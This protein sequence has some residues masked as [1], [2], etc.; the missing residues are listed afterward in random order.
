MLQFMSKQAKV[1]VGTEAAYGVAM[2]IYGFVLNLFFLSL[3]LN[4]TQIGAITS[5]G[6]VVMGA[7][8][9]PLGFLARKTG[10][11]NMYAGGVLLIGANLV[12]YVFCPVRLLLF[13]V[14]FVAVGMTMVEV[15]EVQVMYQ[16]CES[17]RERVTVFSVSFATFSLCSALG[18][19]VAGRLPQFIGYRG[20]L[21]A[22]GILTVIVG[23]LRWK[24]LADD[25]VADAET[26]RPH[27]E[28][29]ALKQVLDRKFFS[30]LAVIAFHGALTNTIGP[31]STLILKYRCDWP[32]SSISTVLT[33]ASVCSFM[34]AL[35]TP[36]LQRKLYNTR[37]YVGVYGALI[38][39]LAT[40][41]VIGNVYLFAVL[42]VVRSGLEIM[43][44]NMI[45]SVTYLTLEESQKDIY[46]GARSLTKGAVGALT[47]L[48]VGLL[49]GCGE[50]GLV[51]W[52]TTGL[53]VC[54]A[55]LFIF[56]IAPLFQDKKNGERIL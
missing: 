49:L 34:F 40:M 16:S 55:I 8:A 6:I 27:R 48:V 43:L 46:A 52:M 32:D 21:L 5:A 9:L 28:R 1:Y 33:L 11:K 45:D 22:S 7:C 2:G 26:A 42:F 41:A 53:M 31:F 37:I 10:R 17:D 56:F 4:A 29:V 54:A 19:F 35:Y 18:T 47:A 36:R 25:R 24:M 51:F 38:A 23:S 50:V 14:V 13:P 15:S 30:F 12:L 20:T 39:V 44:K 3:G